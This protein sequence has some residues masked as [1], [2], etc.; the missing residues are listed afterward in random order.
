LRAKPVADFLE[1]LTISKCC[2]ALHISDL[3]LIELN[4]QLY[5]K[6]DERCEKISFRS[7]HIAGMNDH[8]DCFVIYSVVAAYTPHGKNLIK[9]MSNTKQY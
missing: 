8:L 9:A 3:R 7:K 4:Q 1:T 6:R 2:R 5:C